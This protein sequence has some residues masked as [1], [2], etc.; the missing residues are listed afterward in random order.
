MCT[1]SSESVCNMFHFGCLYGSI[2]EIIICHCKWGFQHVFKYWLRQAF[3]EEIDG[4][5]ISYSIAGKMC[6]IFEFGNILVN[7]WEPHATVVKVKVCALLLLWVHKLIHELL[8]ELFPYQFDVVYSWVQ[9]VNPLFHVSCCYTW[10]LIHL[11]LLVV[12]IVTITIWIWDCMDCRL[13]FLEPSDCTLS[14][15]WPSDGGLQ[16]Q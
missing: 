13:P 15:L 10:T 3:Q 14:P 11:W 2:F 16:I 8:W 5:F 6:Q 9:G 12:V 4:F 7:V 1:V